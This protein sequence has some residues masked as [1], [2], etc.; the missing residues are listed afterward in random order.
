[1]TSHLLKLGIFTTSSQAPNFWE[2]LPPTQWDFTLLI[3]SPLHCIGPSVQG[4]AYQPK[5]GTLEEGAEVVSHILVKPQSVGFTSCKD[6]NKFF[7]IFSCD[8][9]QVF[10]RYPPWIT[11]KKVKKRASIGTLQRCKIMLYNSKQSFIWN[12][13]ESILHT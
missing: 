11:R 4:R 6:H 7:F 12:V 10:E 1:M 13:F 5:Q 9:L 2:C 3:R 8:T